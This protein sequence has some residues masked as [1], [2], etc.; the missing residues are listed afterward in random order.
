MLVALV[1][2]ALV[3][4]LWRGTRTAVWVAIF[5]LAFLAVL[6]L[7]HGLEFGETALEVGLAGLLFGWRRA[8]PVGSRNRPRPVLMCAGV[9]AWALAYCAVLAGPLGS[10]HRHTIRRALHHAIRE[11]LR[12]S[13]G[14]P[15]LSGL[16]LLLIE[17]L[18][19]CAVAISVLAVR[20]LL[21]PAAGGEGHR[22]EEYRAARAIAERCGED[23]LS[24]F[25]L[26][27]DK[28]FHFAAEGVLAYRVIGETA[29]ISGDP[30]APEGAA[31]RVLASFLELARERGWQVT[32]WGASAR[33]LDGYR[34]LGLRAVCVGEEAFVDPARFTL[35][36]RRVRKLRQSVH[37]VDRRDWRITVREGHDIDTS[38]EREMDALEGAWRAGRR[39]VLGFAMGMGAFKAELRVRDLYLLAR[40]PEGE[41]RAVMRFVA[42]CGKLSL[43]TMRRVGETP[44][45]LNEALVSRALEVAR[46]RAVLE[47]SLNYAGLAHLVRAEV[48]GG[49]TTP[50]LNRLVLRL[51]GRRFQLERLVRFNEKFLPEWR[52]RFLIYESRGAFARSAVRVLQAEGYLPQPRPVRLPG[53]WRPLRRA[54]PGPAHA[55]AAG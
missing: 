25:I 15:H 29:V 8:F 9:G 6:K 38:L 43:D 16:W 32:V 46:D 42:H 35:E 40:S 10:G 51:L 55:N 23:S 31:P 54:L 28:A 4:R 5:A 1:L 12:V 13:L 33:H 45:G 11:A 7:L 14:Q 24:P 3:P 39:R 17:V 47:V 26:R 18:I 52:P 37:R 41:L 50:C 19:G 30:I 22:E 48:V 20:S 53:Q 49:R 21:R 36:G 2:L 27:P 44:N 34:A